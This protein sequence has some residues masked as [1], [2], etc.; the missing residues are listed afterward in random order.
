MSSDETPERVVVLELLAVMKSA[1]DLR[2]TL[3]AVA[4][5]KNVDHSV[6]FNTLDAQSAGSGTHYFMSGQQLIGL[7]H[8]V[9]WLRRRYFGP[10]QAFMCPRSKAPNQS[11]R[12]R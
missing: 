5:V 7:V 9:F 10:Q 1:L 8:V 12:Q 2:A 3:P 6:A 4:G 11:S